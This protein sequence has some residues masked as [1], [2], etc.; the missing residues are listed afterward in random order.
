[1]T[2]TLFAVRD[3]TAAVLC[4]SPPNLRCCIPDWFYCKRSDRNFDKFVLKKFTHGQSL[5][6]DFY[7]KKCIFFTFSTGIT[8]VEDGISK[9]R[10]ER[11]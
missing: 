4:A 7:V 3:F 6:S 1:L 11:L 8:Q 10:S 2:K 9:I 5:T